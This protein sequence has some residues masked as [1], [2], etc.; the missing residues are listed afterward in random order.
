M[1]LL[2]TVC[3]NIVAKTF[4]EVTA[5]QNQSRKSGFL[6]ESSYTKKIGSTR[7]TGQREMCAFSNISRKYEYLC[8][9]IPVFFL[10]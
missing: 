1:S 10:Q 4:C 5:D 8:H 3:N 2:D 9:G 7:F 6:P